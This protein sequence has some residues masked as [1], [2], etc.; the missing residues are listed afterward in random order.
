MARVLITVPWGDAAFGRATRLPGVKVVDSYAAYAG[1]RAPKHLTGP[2]LR[3][4]S[5]AARDIFARLASGGECDYH[6]VVDSVESTGK[7]PSATLADSTR[8]SWLAGLARVIAAQSVLPDDRGHALAIFDAIVDAA[9]TGALD[10][11]QQTVYGQLLLLLERYER[12]DSLVPRLAELPEVIARY[13]R[14]D[15]AN[16]FVRPGK[17]LDAWL[18]LA[19]GPESSTGLEP[20]RLLP[21]GA[22]PFDRLTASRGGTLSDGPLV[23]VIM[24]AYRPDDSVD[25]AVRSIL[26]QT[27]TN[28]ELII[29]DDAS[30]A[31]YDDKLATA[32]ASD[33]RITLIR[34]EVNGGTYLAR[35]A[36]LDAAAG[37]FITFQDS[38]DW[39]HP[40]RIELQVAPLVDDPE[41]M[42]TRSL[43][44][45]AH[46]NLTHQ[47]LGY[48][49]QRVNASSLQFRAKPVLAKIGYFDSVRK[50][51]D[52]E[53]A[54]RLEAAFGRRIRD[55]R[56]P[57][58]WTR[59]RQTSLSR[60]DFSLGWAAPG[61]IAYQAAYLHWHRAIAEGANPY[62]PR[63][64]LARPFPAPAPYLDRIADAPTPRAHYDVVLLDDWMPHSGPKD[65]AVEE[66]A[67]LAARGLSVGIVHA[68]AVG[69]FTAKREHLNGVIQ[70][71]VNG[72]VVDRL[73][74]DQPVTTSLVI[75]RDPLVLQYPQ[76]APAVLR[77]EQVAICDYL[78]PAGYPPLRVA[79]D[80]RSCMDNGEALFG[81]RPRW[82]TDLDTAPV[83]LARWAMPRH[84]RR[85]DRPVIG[86]Y[87]ADHPR[88]WP[89][90]ATDLLRA[91]PESRSVDVRILGGASAAAAVLG[92]GRAPASW[93]VYGAGQVSLR[94]FVNQV[95]FYVYFPSARVTVPPVDLLVKAMASG[96][97]VLLPERFEEHFGDAAVY[98]APSEVLRTV[99]RLYRDGELYGKQVDA[100][101]AYVLR[102]HA[103]ADYGERVAKLIGRLSEPS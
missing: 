50:S 26:E 31:D 69:Q 78:P 93:L 36:G 9:G 82:D 6:Q 87:D 71:L 15:L 30:G 70:D 56:K 51:A 3:T 64:L 75:V 23:S 83:D 92:R 102:E 21:E 88:T 57:L 65:G 80:E 52:F 76:A 86:R 60:S 66:V 40:R 5:V 43:A 2:A 18:K 46:D 17:T 19:G 79:Y 58:A 54:F 42:G 90:T 27:W 99:R 20:V 49:A 61:R 25:S 10:A 73:T 98:C 4:R 35:N 62:V 89:D 96:A 7:P 38:D 39:S 16:P 97:V 45:R 91:Y 101:R 72:G 103:A 28:L 81:V 22:T 29:V 74:L 48:P 8:R 53:Y 13:L 94:A 14:I 1:S 59:L 85:S 34:N 33:P 95:D 63:R 55:V 67:A 11:E 44:V 84:R 100:A 41:L 68:E 24:T 77:A 47:W 37:E 12:A 32:A